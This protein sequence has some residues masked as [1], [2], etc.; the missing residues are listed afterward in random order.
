MGVHGKI[1][2]KPSLSL[3]SK[4]PNTTSS[5]HATIY[6]SP[7]TTSSLSKHST[8]PSFLCPYWT[9]TPIYEPYSALHYPHIPYLGYL[10]TSSS[11]PPSSVFPPHFSKNMGEH[12]RKRR[13]RISNKRKNE[14][15]SSMSRK[16]IKFCPCFG[17]SW[18]ITW[19][20]G[21][22]KLS[23]IFVTPK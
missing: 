1:Y 5:K 12:R 11:I 7:Q 21:K 4:Y 3:L 20:S 23:Y 14:R 19:R 13:N 15:I 2:I 9:S 10:H 8:K 22:S 6:S 18:W 16:L 17:I